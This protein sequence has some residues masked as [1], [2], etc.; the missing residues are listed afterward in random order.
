M[1]LIKVTNATVELLDEPILI[2]LDKV[3]SVYG[4]RD[5]N[6][7]M[8]TMLYVSPTE[9]WNVKETVNKIYELATENNPKV[10]Q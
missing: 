1:K 3:L 5:N 7:Q 10:P 4:T 2:N 8:V 6:G 9:Y